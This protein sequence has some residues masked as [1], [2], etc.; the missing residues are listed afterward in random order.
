MES[1]IH[2]SQTNISVNK[3]SIKT[4]QARSALLLVSKEHS[5][6][7]GSRTIFNK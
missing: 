5:I 6:I 2:V 3:S 1:Q 7:R 4:K